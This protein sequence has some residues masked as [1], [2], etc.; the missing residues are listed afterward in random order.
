[1]MD[2]KKTKSSSIREWSMRFGL[3]FAGLNLLAAGII[4]NTRSDLGVAAFTS[5]S[6]ALS[7]I[8]NI[9]LGSASIIVYFV[10][11][12]LQIALL[13]RLSF[14]VALQIPFSVV[15]GIL[16]DL[17]DA[18]IPEVEFS[19]AGRFMLLAVAI[20]L[21][22]VGVYLYTNCRLV[23][24]PVEGVVQTIADRTVFQF[25]FVKNGFDLIMLLL[26]V[27]VCLLLRQPIYGIGVGTVVSALLLGRIIGIYEKRFAFLF[28]FI[29]RD[30][31]CEQ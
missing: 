26:T 22:S 16:T 5:F 2:F 19:F 31:A 14:P 20:W 23:M 6:Y 17:Y 13:R 30:K 3:F 21:T 27:L 4:L 7:K 12:M 9:S 24:T 8:M 29:S 15:F 11:I 28:C 18:L 25:S 1:M 10:L